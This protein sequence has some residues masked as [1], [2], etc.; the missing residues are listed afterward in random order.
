MSA[1]IVL[2]DN[3]L[4]LSFVAKRGAE[5]EVFLLALSNNEV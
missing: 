2:Y 5:R 3:W 1:S 4:V